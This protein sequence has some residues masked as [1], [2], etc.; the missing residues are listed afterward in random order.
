MKFVFVGAWGAVLGVVLYTIACRKLAAAEADFSSALNA[1]KQIEGK[2][3]DVRKNLKD[4]DDVLA[5]Q[6]DI[7]YRKRDAILMAADIVDLIREFFKTTGAFL[8]QKAAG[9]SGRCC[10]YGRR[11]AFTN[12]YSGLYQKA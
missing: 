10:R 6:R 5:K 9:C 12:R 7:I 8:S 3:F 11:A 2:N 1:Q 4:Y